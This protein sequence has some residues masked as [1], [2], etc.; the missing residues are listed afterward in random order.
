MDEWT[1]INLHDNKYRAE[2][3]AKQ[4]RS[5]FTRQEFRVVEVVRYSLQMRDRHGTAVEAGTGTG[6]SGTA[7]GDVRGTHNHGGPEAEEESPG[8]DQTSGGPVAGPG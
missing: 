4:F 2:C 7:E 1:D 3:L 5:E 6:D 8:E